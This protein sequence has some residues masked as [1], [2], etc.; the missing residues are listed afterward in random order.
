MEPL[1]STPQQQANLI[2][3][4]AQAQAVKA[5]KM[6]ADAQ[7]KVEKAEKL[8]FQA[9]IIMSNARKYSAVLKERQKKLDR[10]FVLLNRERD[11]IKKRQFAADMHDIMIEE[12]KL[13]F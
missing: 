9:N 7:I 12:N 4:E 3:K 2:V 11:S 13:N 5:G 1:V 10:A 8:M 6:L